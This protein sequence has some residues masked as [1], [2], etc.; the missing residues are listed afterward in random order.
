MKDQ[1]I[2][3]SVICDVY[4]HEQFLHQCFDGFVM[5]KTD[6]KFEVLVHDDASTDKSAEIIMDYVNKYPDIFKPI[7]QTENQF[8]KGDRIWTTYQFPRAKGK[9][10]AFCE[11]DDYWIDPLKLQK[12][13]DFLENHKEVVVCSHTVLNYLQ[14]NNKFVQNFYKLNFVKENNLSLYKYDLDNYWKFWVTQP[15]SCV[16]RN[17]DYLYHMPI[18]QYKVFYD[19][20]FFYYVLKHGKGVLIDEDMGIYRVHGKGIWSSLTKG[21]ALE[22]KI[23]QKM[24]VY[25]NENDRRSLYGIIKL[26]SAF[27][28]HKISDLDFYGLI[29]DLRKYHKQLPPFYTTLAFLNMPVLVIKKIIHT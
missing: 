12:Q 10:L 9:Y 17:G 21:K 11:G 14:K 25:K 24:S 29:T 26:L 7:I 22:L 2:L 27:F 23:Y 8:S 18:E 6:F 1:E 4:N 13:V 5:Q 15:L 16:I 3:L 28:I 19:V 20:T